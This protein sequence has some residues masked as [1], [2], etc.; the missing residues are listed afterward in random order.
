[1]DRESHSIVCLSLSRPAIRLH[2]AGFLFP[3]FYFI[4][5]RIN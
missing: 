3:H 2:V 4:A 1:M 5:T